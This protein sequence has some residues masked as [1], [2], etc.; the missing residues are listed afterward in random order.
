MKVLVIAPHPDDET[1]GAGGT[2]LK[3][4]AAGDEILWLVVTR[5]HEPEWSASALAAKEREIERVS[6]AYGFSRV[7]R[8]GF[9]TARMDTLSQGEIISALRAAIDEARPD[10]LY[11]N[12]AGDVHSDHRIVFENVMSALKPFYTARHGEK[13]I[14]SYEVLSSTDAAPPDTARTFAPTI[15]SDITKTIERKLEIMSLYETE[16]QPAPLPRSL[17]TMRALARVRGA[18]IG[19]EYA[20]GFMLIREV[21]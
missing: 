1:L 18:T 11:L 6:A 16:V 10:T 17:E 12:H 9:Q 7:F 15:F 2:L 19:T 3:H 13:R 14:L 21:A 8:L 20:E 4:K 5:G